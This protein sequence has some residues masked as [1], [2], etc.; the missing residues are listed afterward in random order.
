MGSDVVGEMD[1][2]HFLIQMWCWKNVGKWLNIKMTQK[3]SDITKELE[4]WRS[5]L[6][7]Y[8]EDRW[9]IWARN[10]FKSVPSSL[11]KRGRA[12]V[13]QGIRMG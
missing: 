2:N 3:V 5:E 9:K 8:D 4:Y 6:G 1:R 11:G 7:I 10:R 13:D 12:E